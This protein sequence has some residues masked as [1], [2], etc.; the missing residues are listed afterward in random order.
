MFIHSH[1]LVELQWYHD[2]LAMCF[3]ALFVIK[4]ALVIEL[5]VNFQNNHS[6]VK[7]LIVY[8]CFT[9]PYVGYVCTKLIGKVRI[10]LL[11]FAVA[12]DNLWGAAHAS[13][14]GGSGNWPPPAAPGAVINGQSG[15][16][17]N[18]CLNDKIGQGGLNGQVA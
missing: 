15:L 10:E 13:R 2:S 7:H 3:N 18:I 14:P 6:F 1:Q 11:L 17:C 8:A 9:L 12:E 16:N 5:Y 4:C